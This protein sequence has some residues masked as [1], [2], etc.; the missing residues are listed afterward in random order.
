MKLHSTSKKAVSIIVM[1]LCFVYLLEVPLVGQTTRTEVRL[2]QTM[3]PDLPAGSIVAISRITNARSGGPDLCPDFHLHGDSGEGIMIPSRIVAS[4]GPYF[5]PNSDVC[6]Y[7]KLVDAQHA[8]TNGNDVFIVDGDNNNIS[9]L[10][11][12]D[13]LDGGAGDDAL[14]G[15]PGDD[16]LIGGIGNDLL[17][18]NEQN[19][20]LEGEAGD[21]SLEGG[22]GNDTLAG[23]IG[24]DA[25]T[26]GDGDDIIIV[27]T[28]DVP[29][30]QTETIDGGNGT[31]T[32][33]LNGY[34][35][36]H[37]SS[38]GLIIT[39]TDPVTGGKYTITNVETTEYSMLLAQ[40]ANGASYA[41]SIVL[42]N[43]S[44]LNTGTGTIEFTGDDGNPL[45]LSINGGGAQSSVSFNVPPLGSV[46][47]NTDRL[48]SLV[49]GAARVRVDR[50]L[51]GV[52]RFDTP[53]LGIAGVGESQL[54]DSFITPIV[55]DV[56][57]DLST[58]VA[59][60]NRGPATSLKMVLKDLNGTTVA[61]DY[62]PVP[63]N[64]HTAKF[65]HQLFP[66]L[67]NFQ[68]TLTVTGSTLAATAIQL[69]TKAGQFTTLPVIPVG[70]APAGGT[71]YFAQ[72]GSGDGFSSS[73]FLVNP[74]QTA[75][76][77]GDVAFFNDAGSSLSI[78]VNGAPPASSVPFDIAP[79]GGVVLNADAPGTR[80]V[81]SARAR[82]FSGVIGG[83]LRF[84]LA[85]LGLAGVGATSSFSSFITP[86]RRI[87]SKGLDT[88]IALSSTGAAVQINLTLRR[89]NGET[90]G[91][92]SATINLSANG[93]IARFLS[94]LFPTADTNNF[95]GTVTATV[96]GSGTVA[97]TAIEL[98][99]V[100]GEFTTL[101]VTRIQ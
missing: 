58:G 55:V 92:G 35:Q 28:G 32:V 96:V 101:P 95:Q 85:P 67:N 68:G 16:L 34:L 39:V 22:T 66:S 62:L 19:D 44:A 86:V 25:I 24:R 90:V 18:G 42:T 49:A 3:A 47:L 37:V 89:A 84:T 94:E 4:A 43:P 5:D 40:I 87:A 83:V 64:G 45:N 2:D 8:G 60:V 53:G 14:S 51:G 79:Q 91:G 7:G 52:V 54:V 23:G 29:A 41:S 56:A 31:D 71:L 82:V 9:G 46:E 50:S 33:V 88:G 80:L 78:S 74:S 98:G 73:L 99:Q 11:G 48:G 65:A 61:E 13:R 59:V 10:A 93:H 76:A 72:F 70:P 17:M 1:S 36:S 63:A 26:G 21:D 15:G 57:K 12:N 30:G 97:G 77:Q 6:G 69:G 81:G 100:P 75:R 27:R 38:T 20:V